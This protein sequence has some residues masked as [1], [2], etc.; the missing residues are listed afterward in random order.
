MDFAKELSKA[1]TTQWRKNIW[2]PFMSAIKEYRLVDQGDRIAV[3]ISGGKD[4]M[5]LAK[6]MQ[7]LKK[8]SPLDFELK[9]ICMDP[10]YT[11]ENRSRIDENCS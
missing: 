11:P 10:G 8:R 5:L 9:F 3:C 2:R 7:E 1:L 4:S 6:C